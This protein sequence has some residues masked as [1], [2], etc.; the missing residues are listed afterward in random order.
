MRG[1]AEQ[2][3]PAVTPP[4]QRRTIPCRQCEDVAFS[5]CRNDFADLRGP[6]AK[7][8]EDVSLAV[9]S[10]SG[11]IRDG[12][13][14]GPPI[15]TSVADVVDADAHTATPEV[16]RFALGQKRMAEGRKCQPADESAGA[17][18]CGAMQLR[19]YHGVD[20]VGADK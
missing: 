13:H 5:C 18:F 10:V 15:G 7:S 2:S 3:D 1:V 11:Q 19:P 4:R 14:G 8:P 9:R 12:R 16:D 20:A 6:A 17:R